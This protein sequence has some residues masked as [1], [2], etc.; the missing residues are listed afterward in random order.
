MQ[1]RMNDNHQT[2]HGVRTVG[3]R[4]SV[5]DETR[6]RLPVSMPLVSL[7]SVSDLLVFLTLPGINRRMVQR[8]HARPVEGMNVYDGD[9][10]NSLSRLS[11]NGC[12]ETWENI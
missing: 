8:C 7:G 4:F 1:A 5:F 11:V 9:R 10:N 3:Q 6:K 12:G 2:E